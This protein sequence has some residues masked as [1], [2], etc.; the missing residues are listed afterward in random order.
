MGMG[1]TPDS[2]IVKD[3]QNLMGQ[4]SVSCG[5]T[6]TDY[7]YSTAGYEDDASSNFSFN[8]SQRSGKT[9]KQSEIVFDRLMKIE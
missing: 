9:D 8:K 2:D 5:Q 4:V 3:M 7:A 6:N 1:I